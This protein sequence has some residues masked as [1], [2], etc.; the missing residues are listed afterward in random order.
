MDLQ[1]LFL[2]TQSILAIIVSIF[3]VLLVVAV[4]YI[5]WLIKKTKSKATE[6]ADESMEVAKEA[7]KYISKIGKSAV[8]YFVLKSIRR[9]RKK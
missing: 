6:V 1:S 7:K 2:T 9:I 8:R 5:F 4:L 3:F